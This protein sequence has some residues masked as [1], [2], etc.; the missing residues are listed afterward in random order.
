MTFNLLVYAKE[1][2]GIQECTLI[3]RQI[4][5]ADDD[6]VRDLGNLLV[7][8][9]GQDMIKI[10]LKCSDGTVWECVASILATCVNWLF[11][12]EAEI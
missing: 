1:S 7:E 4:L 10:L 5:E 6:C 12:M 11:V 2:K 9:D 3:I 8:N